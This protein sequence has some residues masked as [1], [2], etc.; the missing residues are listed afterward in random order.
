MPQFRVVVPPTVREG[1]VVRAYVGGNYSSVKAGS[2][3]SSHNP[4]TVNVRVPKGAVPGD[5][6][7]FEISQDR[8]DELLRGAGSGSKAKS[9]GSSSPPNTASST[10]AV[11]PAITDTRYAFNGTVLSRNATDERRLGLTFVLYWQVGLVHRLL[12]RNVP[13]VP[14][15]HEYGVRLLRGS[16]LRDGSP[17]I[18]HAWKQGW[19]HRRLRV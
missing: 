2:A 14:D 11:E 3:T 18:T 5:A 16:S 9:P 1:Q 8:I 10:F 7:I 6:F 17:L 15:R 13:G 19:Y 4:Q 12:Q